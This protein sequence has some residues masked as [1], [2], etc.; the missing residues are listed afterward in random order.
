MKILVLGGAGYIG[1]HTVY[2]LIDAGEEVVIIDNLETGHIEAVHPK[3]K[4]YKGDLRDKDF[5]DSVLDQEKDIDAV[6]HFAAN[7][8]VGE[9]MVNPLKYYDN[10][11]CGTKTMVQSLVEHGIDKI[12]FSSTAA[13][14]GE[15]EKV[16]IVETDRTEPT[17][18]YGETKLSMEKMF[19]WVGR[20]HGLRYVSLRYFNAC[21]AHVSGIMLNIIKMDL[22]RMLKTKSMYVIW[23]VLAAILLITTSLCKTDYELSTE[24]DAMKQ[25]QVTEPT[26]D[27]INVGMMVTL[28]TE[29]GEKVTVYD[30]FF[31]NS[32]GKLYA[33]LLVIFTVLFSTAD[34]SSGYIKNIG[35]QVRN[36]G[37]LIFSRAIALAVFTVLTMAG[38]FLFQAAANGIFFGE[39]EWGNTKAIL[40]YF[41]TE[42][43][44]HYALVLICMA[45]AIIL[46][47]NVISMVIAVCLSM[48][49]MTIV[50]GVINSAIQKIGIQNFQIYKYTITG[51]LSLLPMNPSGNE[52][53][54]AFG[55]AIVF[56]VIMIS[57][58]S[59][60]FQKR[61]I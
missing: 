42:L 55:V 61:N 43:A 25:E 53:L 60:V 57:V 4:F 2:E 30:I 48:N 54:A 34:I 20:A 23:I 10:N 26:V 8:L 29:P 15:P 1:S 18:T 22:Y 19:K 40:S 12:V 17:N 59:V 21:G 5:V 52:C 32:Q 7:S 46:K 50:Y 36:R 9:S 13:T 44:L 56:I 39:L 27:N 16:P 11:L 24:K 49:V 47:N 35:G 45:I 28:P 38:A 37:T 6:I 41:V 3:A 51:K 14:Y 33:L 58:S 31:A